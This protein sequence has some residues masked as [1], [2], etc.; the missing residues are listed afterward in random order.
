MNKTVN[1]FI[2]TLRFRQLG[3]YV[4]YN[5]SLFSSGY[6]VLFQSYCI[7]VVREEVCLSITLQ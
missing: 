1:P 6:T 5:I 3:T 7:F 4:V 2:Q